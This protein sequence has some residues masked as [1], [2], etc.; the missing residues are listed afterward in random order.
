MLTHALQEGRTCDWESFPGRE[1]MRVELGRQSEPLKTQFTLEKKKK[2]RD[3]YDVPIPSTAVLYGPIFKDYEKKHGELC[4]FVRENKEKLIAFW[5]KNRDKYP[6]PLTREEQ[7]QERLKAEEKRKQQALAKKEEARKKRRQDLEFDPLKI[8]PKGSWEEYFQ[9]LEA[10]RKGID[11]KAERQKAKE[12]AL[13]Q[14]AQMEAMKALVADL[15]TEVAKSND[16]AIAKEAQLEAMKALVHDISTNIAD[17][18]KLLAVEEKDMGAIVDNKGK[19]V[20]VYISDDD[21]DDDWGD[22]ELLYDGTSE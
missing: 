13:A 10:S 1:K 3:K 5:R 17:K 19:G 20:V 21:D 4:L 6:A 22:D 15:P 18:G 12:A 9:A 14:E 16:Q 11:L 7:M 2:I 8:F